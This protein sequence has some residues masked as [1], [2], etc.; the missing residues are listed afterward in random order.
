MD[1]YGD[2]VDKDEVCETIQHPLSYYETRLESAPEDRI[3][4]WRA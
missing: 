3:A 4:D 2:C 1:E